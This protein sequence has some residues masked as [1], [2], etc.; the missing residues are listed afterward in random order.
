MVCLS[1]NMQKADALGRGHAR[2]V[3]RALAEDLVAD[4]LANLNLQGAALCAADHLRTLARLDSGNAEGRLGGK[5][6]AAGGATQQACGL[7]GAYDLLDRLR[8]RRFER[9]FLR[10]EDG[11]GPSTNPHAAMAVRSAES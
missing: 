11:G 7:L 5:R 9:R 1:A 2:L 3:D 8:E 6:C 10:G 4:G